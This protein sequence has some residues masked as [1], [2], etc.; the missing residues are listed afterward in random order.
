MCVSKSFHLSAAGMPYTI[1]CSRFLA[2]G[3]AVSDIFRASAYWHVDGPEGEFDVIFCFFLL[4]VILPFLSGA[5]CIEGGVESGMHSSENV[6]TALR[7][8][9]LGN[10]LA[11]T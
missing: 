5:N 4:G 6:P 1:S 3:A 9:R 10:R 8:A 7:T 11:H 2:A